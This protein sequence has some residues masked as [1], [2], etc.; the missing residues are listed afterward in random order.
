MIR[1]S[2]V[3][4]NNSQF[5]NVQDDKSYIR[6]RINLQSLIARL[7]STH[8][9]CHFLK[10]RY[11]A[12]VYIFKHYKKNLFQIKKVIIAFFTFDEDSQALLTNCVIENV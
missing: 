9:L 11:L 5:V 3:L 12:N 6:N 4:F 7:K 10:L 2:C 1:N 8:F